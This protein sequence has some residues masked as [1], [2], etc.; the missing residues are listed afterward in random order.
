[1][2]RIALGGVPALALAIAWLFA[3]TV[4]RHTRPMVLP[5]GGGWPAFAGA[6]IA[7]AAVALGVYLAVRGLAGDVAAVV[8][9]VLLLGTAPFAQAV[10]AAAWPEAVVPAGRAWRA[11]WWDAASPLGWPR[12][13]ALAWLAGA[14]RLIARRKL[15]GAALV[16][17]SLAALVA[18]LASDGARWLALA[19]PP[20]FVVIGGA[21]GPV[22]ERW[23]RPHV[24][25]AVVV[26]AAFAWFAV[27]GLVAAARR[28]AQGAADR[29]AQLVPAADHVRRKLPGARVMTERALSGIR[30]MA[31]PADDGPGALFEALER[32]APDQRPSHFALDPA[33][34]A[35]A[36]A[37]ELA[38]EMVFRAPLRPA[39][40]PRPGRADLQLFAA[41]WDHVGTG[42][43][44]LNDHAGWAIVD[45]LDVAD[46]ASEAAHAWRGTGE[47]GSVL[48]REVGAHGLILDG[49]R[50][51]R[52]ERFAIAVDPARPIRLI[53]RTG[54]AR[55][56]PAATV[57][58]RPVGLRLLDAAGR[59]LGRASLAV[60][61][62]AFAEV[63]FALPAGAP[64]ELRSEATGP[65]RAFHW[66]VLQPE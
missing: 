20:M 28:F 44:P 18:A 42:E 41:S 5:D 2:R 37:L 48:G 66:F 63:S 8:A 23:R 55:A 27:P 39:F 40:A 62:G 65:Y 24:A 58:E 17:G 25:A 57:I 32:L 9:A 10:L 12:I 16:A 1:V 34:P 14:A 6:T 3:A 54:G 43:R 51:L 13:L 15:V 61:A 22:P 64:A 26:V 45:R 29:N 52:G 11:L 53:L 36:G 49:G 60:P 19:L 47:P 4:L 59:E 21:L 38:G 7:L 35:A 30:T 50:T 46:R 31:L 33:A 56:Y